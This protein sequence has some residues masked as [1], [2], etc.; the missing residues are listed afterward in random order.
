MCGYI[1]VFD[2]YDYVESYDLKRKTVDTSCVRA[3]AI[4]FQSE[5]R[6]N[7]VAECL[8]CEVRNV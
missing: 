2:G 8:N 3:D 7:Y 1:L 4:V 6:A 5:S